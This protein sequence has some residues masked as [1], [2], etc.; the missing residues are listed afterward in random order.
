MSTGDLKNRPGSTTPAAGDSGKPEPQNAPSPDDKKSGRVKF[1]DR[2]NAVWEWSVATG[3]F[4]REVTTDRLKK[5]ENDALSLADDAPT[6]LGLVQSN[7]LGAVKGYNPYD[8]G[9]LGKTRSRRRR[10]IF[11]SSATGSN[12]R[13]RPRATRTRI[14]ASRVP[15]LRQQLRT[16]RSGASRRVPAGRTC[17]A[18]APSPRS[19]RRCGRRSASPGAGRNWPRSDAPSDSARTAPAPAARRSSTRSKSRGCTCAG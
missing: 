9:K 17:A 1:D 8:S 14:N 16:S 6:P 10:R 15:G 4:G 11:A 5:L 2:G 18:P 7:P 3:A 13:S 12:S 19:S